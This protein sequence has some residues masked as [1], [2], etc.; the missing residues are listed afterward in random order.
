M[1][2]SVPPPKP[3]AKLPAAVPS[4]NW[5]PTLPTTRWKGCYTPTAG[6]WT[7]D[8]S[9]CCSGRATD[10]R[11][12]RRATG[13][14]DEGFIAIDKTTEHDSADQSPI[15]DI[16]GSYPQQ[17][18]EEGEETHLPPLETISELPCKLPSQRWQKLVK[19]MG[20]INMGVVHEKEPSAAL[21]LTHF[22]ED[23]YQQVYIDSV[24]NETCHALLRSLLGED[25][26]DL[27]ASFWPTEV[28][29]MAPDPK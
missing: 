9:S 18:Q 6:K 4:R 11:S 29:P 23:L 5:T 17:N 28:L 3:V 27:V 2:L 15:T 20:E 1:V 25:Y 8:S 10:V 14:E 21:V 26:L 24:N 13:P 16:L 12:S 19:E 7:L 22:H